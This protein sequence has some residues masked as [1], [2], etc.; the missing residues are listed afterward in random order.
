MTAWKRAKWSAA[1]SL[2]AL[3]AAGMDVGPAGATTLQ[4]AL[5]Q[6]YKTN[7]QLLAERARLRATDEEVAQAISLWR[8]TITASGTASDVES[9]TRIKGV[10]GVIEGQT[11]PWSANVTL[12]QTIFAGGRILAQRMLAGAQVRAGRANLHNVEQGVLLNT[13]SAYMNVVRDLEVVKS[14]EASVALLRKQ[15]EAAQE[16]FRVGEVTRTDVAQAEARLSSTEAGLIAAQASLKASRLE[17]ERV[18]GIPP[19]NLETQPA[20]P[21]VP[22]SED[23][24]IALAAKKAPVLV[25]AAENENVSRHAVN[26][27][28]GSLLPTVSVQATH[29]RSNAGDTSPSTRTENTTVSG[30]LSVPLYQGGAEWSNIRQAEENLNQSRLNLE[31]T[32]RTTL[33]SASNAWE[34]LRAAKGSLEANLKQLKAQEIAF[35]GVK[36]EAEVGT[37]TTIDVLDAQRELLNSQVSVARSR[38]DEIVAAH[39]LLAATGGL[40]AQ[41]LA[42]P[43]TIYD[44]LENYDDNAGKWFGLSSYDGDAPKN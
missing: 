38:R 33:E 18:V 39:Q 16:R 11:E 3:L 27:S 10:P 20:V 31:Q 17:Y 26:L 30:V 37:R 15:L 32:R 14:N 22:S 23:E 44:P 2:V 42:L 28:V 8:P 4:E 19:E 5:V 43:T 24:A 6:A 9:E 40:T 1:V 25:A 29:S 13:V 36:Q 12:N 21:P 35:E 41:N 7:P 34:G